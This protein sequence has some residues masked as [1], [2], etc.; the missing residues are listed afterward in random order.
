[1]PSSLLTPLLSLSML[2]IVL[3]GGGCNNTSLPSSMP[4]QAMS[5][6]EDAW[7][8]FKEGWKSANIDTLL[9]ACA[10]TTKSQEYCRSL[11]EAIQASGHV[12]DFSR[13]LQEGTLTLKEDL[14]DTR[15]YTFIHEG[16]GSTFRFG[17]YDKIGWKLEE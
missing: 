7:N 16:K 17:L 1:M 15:Y 5:T 9:A 10:P 3:L 8:M 11:F 13:D 6:P 12:G 14:Q 2:V 4:T